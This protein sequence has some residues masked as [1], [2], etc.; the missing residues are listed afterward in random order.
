[1]E[2]RPQDAERGTEPGERF[3]NRPSHSVRW[4]AW[5]L[6][7]ALLV[8]VIAG[9]MHFSDDRAF[10]RLAERAEPRW[11]AAALLL[12]LGTYVAQGGIWRRV[13]T[14]C[15]SGLS[16]RTAF[17][18]SLAKLFVD[19][20]LPSAGVSSSVLIAKALGRRRLPTS[21]VKATV[22]VNMASYQ[23]AYVVAL[24]VAL[25]IIVVSGEGR[26]IILVTAALFLAFSI[27]L[28]VAVLGLP[29]R[30]HE[31][32]AHAVGR[33]PGLGATVRFVAGADPRLVRSPRL[34]IDT[35]TLQ[36]IIVML[37]ALTIWVLLAA[38]GE[39]ASPSGVFAAFMVASLFRTMG[40]APGGLGTFEASSVLMLRIVGVPVAAGLSATL[41]FRGFSFWIPMVPGYWFSRRALTVAP[42]PSDS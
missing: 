2:P 28:C 29:G 35:T 17:E 33:V 18:L 8:S 11:L 34:L 16:H 27:A 3:R 9:G 26:P 23:I 31:R 14:A 39:R 32:L 22:L 41:L 4:L 37:D 5:L 21:A 30:S 13:A 20:A 6:G 7:A 38:L 19:Q 36:A 12:Q 42:D 10:V 40:V 25:T 1:M 15:G 24:T